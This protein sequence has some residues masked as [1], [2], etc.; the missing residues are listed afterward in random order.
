MDKDLADHRMVLGQKTL[1]DKKQKA[2]EAYTRAIIGLSEYLEDLIEK[3]E[4]FAS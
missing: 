3:D 4:T 1:H 2:N